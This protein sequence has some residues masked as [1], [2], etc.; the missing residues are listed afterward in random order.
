[1]KFR[2]HVPRSILFILAPFLVSIY[3]WG[4]L[5]DKNEEPIEKLIE[6]PIEELNTVTSTNNPLKFLDFQKAIL[7][8]PV[9]DVKDTNTWIQGASVN[10]KDNELYIARQ[11]NGGLVLT[12]ERRNLSTGKVKDTK[13]VSI[14]AGTY[15]EGLPWFTNSEGEL[16]FFV[17][18]VPVD[19]I[20]IFNYTNNKVERT[21]KLLGGSKIG[22]DFNKKIF[23]TFNETLDKIY[24]YD[25]ASATQGDPHLLRTIY[26]KGE[27]LLFEKPQGITIFKDK[28]IISHG[29]GYGNPAVS[30]VNMKGKVED[31]F[32]F[33]LIDYSEMIN[34]TYPNLITNKENYHY[35]N[36]GTF[37]FDYNGFLYP[38]LVQV[39]NIDTTLIVLSGILEGKQ[40]K[41]T[42]KIELR[43]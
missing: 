27:E 21:V 36:E 13:R 6:K 15:A 10:Q 22:A 4:A 29:S 20:S 25:F 34:A 30:V 19:Q 16:C 8:F 40:I 17:R 18:Q 33:S 43:K 7:K 9:R 41:K 28:I 14:K 37:M 12:I 35:E 42:F 26:I 2:N 24:L 31:V 38:A 11:S 39:V 3:I 32:Y 1:L 23:V 5:Y